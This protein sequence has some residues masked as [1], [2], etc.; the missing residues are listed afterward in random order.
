MISIRADALRAQTDVLNMKYKHY[1]YFLPKMDECIVWTRQQE[2]DE[3]D[4]LC[5]ILRK[6]RE[7]LQEQRREFLVLSEMLG[8]IC[9]RYARA[10]QEIVD[11]LQ[12]W[13]RAEGQIGAVKLDSLQ[14]LLKESGISISEI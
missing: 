4:E 7:N 14:R 8:R 5:R 9:D 6:E 13:K 3:V 11:S 1:T 12:N 10:E 2:F